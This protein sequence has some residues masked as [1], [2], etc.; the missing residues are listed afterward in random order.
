MKTENLFQEIYNENYSRVIGLCMGYVSGDEA[1]AKDLSQEVFLKVWN[2]L[3]NFRN[4]S[5]LST[6]IYRITVN[7]CLEQLKRRRPVTLKVDPV[8]DT[9]LDHIEEQDK[10]NRMYRCID[11]LSASN[12]SII[13]LELEGLPQ[14]EIAAVTGF[15]H[16]AVRTRIYRIKDQ[17]SKCVNHE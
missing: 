2:N 14:A 3:E 4:Q 6:W 5:K 16:E 9:S 12:K 11:K 10:Y 7:T 17:L 13:L 1:L 15:S 8:D